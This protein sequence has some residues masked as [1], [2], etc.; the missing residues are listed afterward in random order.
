MREY[1][2]ISGRQGA[3]PGNPPAMSALRRELVRRAGR[4]QV[5][6]FELLAK[7]SHHDY[8]ELE[9]PRLTSTSLLRW[10]GTLS[11]GQGRAVLALGQ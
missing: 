9:R 5:E 4:I 3:T 11:N 6:T 2:G 7:R 10:S 8:E 1:L